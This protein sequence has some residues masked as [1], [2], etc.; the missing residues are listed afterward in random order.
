M[1]HFSLFSEPWI[2]IV[3]NDRKSLEQVFTDPTLSQI[4]GRATEKIAIF[5]FLLAIAQRAYT[6]KDETDWFKLRPE[7]LAQAALG[8]LQKHREAFDLYGE[9]PFLQMPQVRRAAIKP[10]ATIVPEI[11][12]GN[13]T[14]LTHG[15][16]ARYF[17]DAEIAVS[18]LTLQSFAL[19]G[20]RTDNSV[21]LSPHYKG[22]LN[23]KGKPSTGKSGPSLDFCGLL[24]S[25]VLGDTLWE[26]LWLNLWTQDFLNQDKQ[27]ALYP[28]GLG[29]PPWERM[30]EG[31]DCPVAREYRE[32]LIGR[33]VP[34]SRY[35]L[36]DDQNIYLTEGIKYDG[37]KE[38]KFDPTS[39]VTNTSKGP[40]T[41]WV[42][43]EK[44]PWRELTSLLNQIKDGS[45]FECQQVQV[46][47]AHCPKLKQELSEKRVSFW[48]GGL[49]VSS[50]A[51]EQYV[52]GTDD[53][54][55]SVVEL[56][57]SCFGEYWYAEFSKQM[58]DLELRAKQ[59]YGCILHYQ[60]TMN[61][62]DNKAA[63]LGV[64]QFWVRSESNCQP[65]LDACV[66]EET[67]KRDLLEK[68]QKEFYLTACQIYDE[69]CPNM[70][71]R[72]MQAWIKSR[73]VRLLKAK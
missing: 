59:L 22:K 15:Q 49:R 4:G 27:K 41:L 1:K 69:L 40:K 52:S 26:S 3:G 53:Y 32:T 63:A 13:T 33:L 62:A 48:S 36:V 11:A 39:A 42:D 60:K 64:N 24:H 5:K 34:L 12:S 30:P 57:L 58:L 44:R 66:E 17:S 46:F 9:Q 14:V 7:G 45:H 55:E 18:L 50:N 73:P 23:H 61:L 2:P 68:L 28:L 38:G 10:F 8:Y 67:V 31:E 35:C 47:S 20:K 70:T 19:G 65:L 43:P 21:V 56:S 6:P 71:A 54:I 25:F 51:G 29:T 72:Q 37:Y 16:V